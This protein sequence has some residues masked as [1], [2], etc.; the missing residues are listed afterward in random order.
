MFFFACCTSL[1]VCPCVNVVSH[2]PSQSPTE[3]QVDILTGWNPVADYN[4]SRIPHRRRLK[5]D[6]ILTINVSGKRFRVWS[7]TLEAFPDTLLGNPDDRQHFYD[8]ENDEYFFDRDPEIFRH[9]L[10][11]YRSGKLHYPRT[12]CI[13]AVDDELAYFGV[14]QDLIADCC[15]E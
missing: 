3:S 5:H 14:S 1:V 15:Y 7:D 2:S 4:R 9:I 12:E 8:P 10:T 13:G 11:Y 6:T